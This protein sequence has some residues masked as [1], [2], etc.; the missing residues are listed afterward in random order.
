MIFFQSPGPVF[1]DHAL[2][3]WV[4][5]QMFAKEFQ[6]GRIQLLMKSNAIE[7]VGIDADFRSRRHLQGRAG[8][9]E[10]KVS[11]I[12]YD[13]VI[14]LRRQVCLDGG[15]ELQG[16]A[17]AATF[18]RPKLKRCSHAVQA[19]AVEKPAEGRIGSVSERAV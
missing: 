12:W 19:V 9:G 13:T 4:F 18:R 7:A 17:I 15:D 8:G 1:R 6:Y 3:F 2:R 16:Y 14:R 11:G 5:N 10:S